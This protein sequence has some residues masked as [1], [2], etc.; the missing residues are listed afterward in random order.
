LK[1]NEFWQNGGTMWGLL[2]GWLLIASN[3]RQQKYNDNL[4]NYY[5]ALDEI[6]A[7]I[8]K[9][10]EEGSTF[11][12]SIPAITLSDYNKVSAE[13]INYILGR[14][15]ERHPA[16]AAEIWKRLIETAGYPIPRGYP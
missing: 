8:F 13:E 9:Y 5:H 10:A 2:L 1:L 11:A 4:T 7:Q 14:V 6:V 15:A 3:S 16:V 12:I